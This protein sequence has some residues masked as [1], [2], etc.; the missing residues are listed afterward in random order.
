MRVLDL[1]AG[2][3]GWSRPARERGHDVITLDLDP[4]FGTDIVA[5]VIEWD[6]PETLVGSVDLVTASPPCDAFSVLNIGK[7]WTKPPSNLPK[8]PAAEQALRIVVG[9]LRV[10]EEVRPRWYVIENPR[11]K[12]RRVIEDRWPDLGRTRQTVTYC[13]YDEPMMKP[14]DLWGRFPP[15]LVLRPPCRSG[16]PCHIKAPRGSTSATQGFGAWKDPERTGAL[17]SDVKALAREFYGTSDAFMLAALRARIPR[18][19]ASAFV[20]AA[21][22][23]LAA[24]G[25]LPPP[26]PVEFVDGPGQLRLFAG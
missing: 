1:C 8:T 24:L 23:D 12:L 10:I 19:L 22:A 14:T 5:D 16:D 4:R 13:Q 2:L 26:P 3:G 18:S 11:A 25:V 9:C 7:N 21:E 20:D 6:V 15:S 17:L